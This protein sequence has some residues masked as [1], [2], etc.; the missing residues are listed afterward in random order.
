MVII[1]F[2]AL[3]PQRL[4]AFFKKYLFIYRKNYNQNDT[5]S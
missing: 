4:I 2:F 5:V 1:S 3:K